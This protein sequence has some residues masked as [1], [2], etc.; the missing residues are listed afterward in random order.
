MSIGK[1]GRLAPLWRDDRD[2]RGEA[3]AQTNRFNPVFESLTA[4]GIRA[5]PAIYSDDMAER[6]VSSF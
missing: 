3:T 4:L 2:S 5:E 1:A 6:F